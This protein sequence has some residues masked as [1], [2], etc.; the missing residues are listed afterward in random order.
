MLQR[1]L[2]GLGLSTLT[3]TVVL[4]GQVIAVPVFLTHWGVQIYG[5]WLTMTN[6]VAG[7][8][9]LNFGVQ[10][11]VIN[12]LIACHVRGEKEEGILILHS[13]LRLY[14][15]L[16]SLALAATFFLACWPDVLSWLRISAT[17]PTHARLILGIQGVMV[18]YALI[19]GLLLTL[20]LVNNQLPRQLAYRLIEKIVY[21]FA[22]IGIVLLGGYALHA[23]IA[24]ALFILCVGFVSLRDVYRR[25]AFPIGIS[26]SSWKSS[27]GLIGPS[28][29]FFAVSIAS[30][31]LSTG[32]V[33]VIATNSGA[34]TVAIF[35]TTLM[36]SNFFLTVIHQGL[37]VLW[38]EIAAAAASGDDTL[39]LA[40]WHRLAL[41]LTGGFAL[42]AIT[43][44]GLLGPKVLAYWTRGSI[45]VDPWLNLALGFYFFIQSPILVSN[46]FGLAMSRQNEMFKVQLV[47]CAIS[48]LLGV[49][50]VPDFGARGAGLA[51]IIGHLLVAPWVIRMACRWTFDNVYSLIKE[52][53]RS[54]PSVIVIL[55]ISLSALYF[56]PDFLGRVLASVFVVVVTPLLCWKTWLTP[57]ERKLLSGKMASIFA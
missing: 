24:T 21:V 30:T 23:S 27:F 50:L 15:V 42:I 1:I 52:L 4:I 39:R 5:E 28:L 3:L 9:V 38:P 51:M 6:L 36:L 53:S 44:I 10:T 47:T 56:V 2:S 26:A 46:A 45:D 14:I 13:A 17:S 29:V 35:S 20:F 32:M 55:I 49:I 8:S 43:G 18:S 7:L 16:C 33:V 57:L 19:N 41:K 25:S 22:P 11:H 40:R 12:R 48:I 37:N 34:A 54:I 31:L